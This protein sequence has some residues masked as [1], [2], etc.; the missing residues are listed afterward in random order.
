M[1]KLGLENFEAR[2][3]GNTLRNDDTATVNTICQWWQ[4]DLEDDLLKEGTKWM[5]LLSDMTW[6]MTL[7]KIAQS[8]SECF[9]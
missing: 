4:L 5:F 7:I 1:G 8:E 6:T 2:G 9:Y 3:R